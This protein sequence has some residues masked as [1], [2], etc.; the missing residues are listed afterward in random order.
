MN[1]C[2]V[3]VVATDSPPHLGCVDEL[4]V[5][6]EHSHSIV[7]VCL[8]PKALDPKLTQMGGDRYVLIRHRYTWCVCVCVCGCG[9]V[10]AFVWV[11]V[12]VCTC[13]QMAF[14]DEA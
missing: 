4:V 3:E 13:G 11:C 1:S 6:R 9:C 10:C 7:H 14:V 5:C 12:S 8:R 2:L